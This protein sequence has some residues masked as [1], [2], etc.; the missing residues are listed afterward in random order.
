[1][2]DVRMNQCRLPPSP[3]FSAREKV[4]RGCLLVRVGSQR[5]ALPRTVREVTSSRLLRGAISRVCKSQ[6]QRGSQILLPTG[7]LRL[8]SRSDVA[9]PDARPCP[10]VPM[11]IR[12]LLR[13]RPLESLAR[14]VVQA[15]RQQA[16]GVTLDAVARQT[17]PHHVRSWC[18]GLP[19]PLLPAC[20]GICPG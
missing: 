4:L 6:V 19:E 14:L 7:R 10:C 13:P 1:M 20:N 17:G 12:A 8:R 3:C 2:S 9:M 11:G 15:E 5:L 18:S 16:G